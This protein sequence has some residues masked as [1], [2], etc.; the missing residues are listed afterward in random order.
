MASA[1]SDASDPAAGT[2]EATRKDPAA[3]VSEHGGDEST[4][5]QAPDACPCN[6]NNPTTTCCIKICSSTLKLAQDQLA[7]VGGIARKFEKAQEIGMVELR[8]STGFLLAIAAHSDVHLYAS[9][10][11]RQLVQRLG[12]SHQ[13]GS[14]NLVGSSNLVIGGQSYPVTGAVSVRVE[15]F[16]EH[17]FA[18][19]D[20]FYVFDVGTEIDPAQTVVPELIFG[21]EHIRLV[22]GLA[23]NPVIFG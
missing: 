9:F 13:I 11:S 7:S 4:G 15:A 17:N 2:P 14:T 18:F 5:S 19:E 6:C 23:L 10:I 12:L 16:S 22:E 21:L 1:A 8:T 20:L 3:G